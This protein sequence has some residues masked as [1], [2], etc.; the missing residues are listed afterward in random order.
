MF[1]IL[2]QGCTEIVHF[3]S[4]AIKFNNEPRW[5]ITLQHTQNQLI[6]M[7]ASNSPQ[8]SQ[9]IFLPFALINSVIIQHNQKKS[10]K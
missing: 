2:N 1:I 4:K 7:I 9:N 3:A 5:I 6:A 10:L 8:I